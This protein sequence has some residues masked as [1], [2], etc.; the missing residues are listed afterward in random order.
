MQQAEEGCLVAA[1]QPKNGLAEL[2][3]GNGLFGRCHRLRRLGHSDHAPPARP[4][5]H[6]AL[7]CHDGK[8]PG[9]EALLPTPQLATLCHALKRRSWT[10]ASA[11]RLR[12]MT[13]ASRCAASRALSSWAVKAVVSSRMEALVAS[14]ATVL[15]M[16]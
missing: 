5:R 12:G 2:A 9:P 8:E 4:A 3:S 7:V 13:V 14:P 10:A 11:A 1:V 16:I 6:P 15:I